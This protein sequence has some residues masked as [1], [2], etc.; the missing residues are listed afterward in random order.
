MSVSLSSRKILWI[1]KNVFFLFTILIMYVLPLVFFSCLPFPLIFFFH[2]ASPNFVQLHLVLPSFLS[3]QK[4]IKFPFFY[5]GL[6]LW[7]H[8]LFMFLFCAFI[9]WWCTWIST[10]NNI[11]KTKHVYCGDIYIYIYIYIYL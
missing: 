10:K 2:P 4:L 5:L 1:L 9:I 7:F 6:L 8:V 11:S 3:I